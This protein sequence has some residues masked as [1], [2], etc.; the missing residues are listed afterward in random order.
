MGK[1]VT[2]EEEQIERIAAIMLRL[3]RLDPERVRKAFQQAAIAITG[4]S[5]GR[6]NS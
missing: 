3:S 2:S 6:N 4:Y 5:N 1:K